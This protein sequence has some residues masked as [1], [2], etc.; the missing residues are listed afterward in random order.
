MYYFIKNLLH[1]MAVLD[2]S[3]TLKGSLGLAFGALF[4]HEFSIEMFFF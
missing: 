4:W 2:Y 3:P 1:A